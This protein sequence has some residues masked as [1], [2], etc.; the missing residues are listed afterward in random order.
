[1]VTCRERC[2]RARSVL[3]VCA[4]AALAASAPASAEDVPAP[5]LPG[6]SPLAA[7]APGTNRIVVMP[8]ERSADIQAHWAARREHVRDRD[9]RRAGD[10]EQRGR[11][12]RGDLA[13]AKP[14]A[15]RSAPGRGKQAPPS[16]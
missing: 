3:L 10:Q 11:T 5:P 13:I 9:E 1:M 6:M 15:A 2:L 12:L 8:S 16:A 14:F 7:P 4:G